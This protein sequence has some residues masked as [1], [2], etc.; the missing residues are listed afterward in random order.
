SGLKNQ[1]SGL[2][3]SGSGLKNQGSGLGAED[4]GFNTWPNFFS[5]TSSAQLLQPILFSP[6]SLTLASQIQ[7]FPTRWDI[8]KRMSHFVFERQEGML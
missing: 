5:P 7:L 6:I 8:R 4:N 2:K 1:G 3:T